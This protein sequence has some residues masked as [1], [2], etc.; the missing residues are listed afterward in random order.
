M[1]DKRR[2]GE[3]YFPNKQHCKREDI[4]HFT[5]FSHYHTYSLFSTIETAEL[6]H[7]LSATAPP[8]F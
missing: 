5:A 1:T 3:P 7:L 8:F 4:L 6:P 2:F